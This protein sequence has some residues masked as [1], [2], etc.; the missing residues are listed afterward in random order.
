MNTRYQLFVVLP[1]NKD[2]FLGTYSSLD[3]L[4]DAKN[5]CNAVSNFR[6]SKQVEKKNM[7]SGRS[8]W[9]NED[10]PSYCSPS[11]ETYWSL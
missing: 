6:V 3:L 2:L 9:E 11:S 7:M 1:F 10:T 8:Y 4:E 5:S